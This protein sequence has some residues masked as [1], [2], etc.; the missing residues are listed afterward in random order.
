MSVDFILLIILLLSLGVFALLA[1]RKFPTLATLRPIEPTEGDVAR[2]KSDI[3]A[4]RLRR[5]VFDRMQ[6]TLRQTKPYRDVL[7]RW[8]Q[9]LFHSI[10]RLER[11]YHHKAKA[12]RT[13]TPHDVSKR[14]GELLAEADDLRKEGDLE[15]A[16]QHYIEVISLQPS[17]VKTFQSL[18]ELYKERQE[19]EQ[20]EETLLHALKLAPEDDS[21]LSDLADVYRSQGNIASALKRC[22]QAVAIHPNDPKNLSA[23]LDVSIELGERELSERTLE[24][25]AIA[26]P[27]NQKL[28]ELRAQVDAL[29]PSKNPPVRKRT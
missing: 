18:G 19:F 4:R 7:T 21:V 10:E 5:K 16:E 17:N 12:L 23:L 29:P 3:I 1:V 6:T 25:L 24:Q 26:N 22:Q 15:H 2:I 20:A 27:E 11:G 9:K 8:A 28:E 13:E 14:I